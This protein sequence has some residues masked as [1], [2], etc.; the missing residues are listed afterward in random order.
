MAYGRRVISE[1][2]RQKEFAFE[3]HQ[4]VI[5]EIRLEKNPLDNICNVCLTEQ[6]LTADHVPPQGTGNRDK[7]RYQSYLNYVTQPDFKKQYSQ[8]GLSWRTVCDECH[9]KIGRHDPAIADLFSIIK[10]Q[11]KVRNRPYQPIRIKPSA[12]IRGTLMHFLSAKTYHSRCV[13]DD[14]FAELVNDDTKPIPATSHFYVFPFLQKEI[15]M[16]NGLGFPI[17][18]PPIAMVH[19]IKIFPLALLWTDQK[20]P[21]DT[22][23]DWARYFDEPVD[24]EHDVQFSTIMPVDDNFPERYMFTGMQLLGRSSVESIIA[25]PW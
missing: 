5:G 9:R 25:W 12:I 15:R 22:L 14:F 6:Q 19:C 4:D 13:S 8:N 7:L 3:A 24:R 23:D 11:Y 10:A 2:G 17:E 1:N 21:I 20:L 16:F 18:D